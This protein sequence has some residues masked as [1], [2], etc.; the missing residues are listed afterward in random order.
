MESKRI[1]PIEELQQA[2]IEIPQAMQILKQHVDYYC[3]IL[4]L[5][6]SADNSS[7]SSLSS[8]HPIPSTTH[9]LQNW[10]ELDI[11]DTDTQ[12][13]QFL[14]QQQESSTPSAS[15][16]LR[17]STPG[18]TWDSFQR[19][20]L[21]KCAWIPKK[22]K[23]KKSHN[24]D[25]GIVTTSTSTTSLISLT[26]DQNIEASKDALGAT[27]I[28]SRRSSYIPPFHVHLSTEENY[29]SE[30]RMFY[31][32]YAYIRK[33]LDYTY[34]RNYKRDRQVLQ[35]AIIHDAMNTIE[36]T[37]IH[38]DVC[39][40]PTEPFLVFTAG[41]MG[42]GKSYTIHHLQRMGRFPLMAFVRVDPDEIRRHLPEFQLY[43][44]HNPSTA[45]EWTRKE[46]GYIAEIMTL[47]A[48]EAGK[49]VIVDGSLRDHEWYKVYF[50]R[51]RR[52][53]PLLKLA[54]LHICA[55]RQAVFARAAVRLITMLCRKTR[56]FY[57]CTTFKHLT[58]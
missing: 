3:E 1:L 9:I 44:D 52:D 38:G 26:M 24:I 2:M 32:P 54:I 50:A 13:R 33:T 21:Q 42:A 48:L 6:Y 8:P 34:H 58:S 49:N 28:P 29:Y 43:I 51:L 12:D 36:L 5:P 56:C 45:G 41:A 53:Y 55:P 27:F 31:G 16:N 39:S 19:Q 30:D 35:D 23:K 40:T 22:F 57:M 7:S 14:L 37:D 47:A 17:I 25:G 15:S 10:N 18:I 20:F 11:P 46:S 4:N